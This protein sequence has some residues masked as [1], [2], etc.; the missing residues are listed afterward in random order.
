MKKI[1]AVIAVIAVFAVNGFSA[2]AV[3][4][5][6]VEKK[7]PVKEVVK[8]LKIAPP[9]AVKPSVV[10]VSEVVVEDFEAEKIAIKASSYMGDASGM[11]ETAEDKILLEQDTKRFM[12]GKKSAKLTY[13]QI[14]A[15]EKKFA[16]ITL[17]SEN[18]MDTNNAISFYVLAEKGKGSIAVN[19]FDT[20]W[21][22]WV[23]QTINADKKEWTL[24]TIKDSEFVSDARE[25]KWGNI[26]RV[27]LIIKGSGVFY[28]DNVKFIKAVK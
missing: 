14:P 19:L 8:D 26:N 11:E 24:I 3:K 22:K 9:E 25:G 13:T 7:A 6:V 15:N 20:K 1:A 4:K 28:F 2:D 17:A 18:A 21:K 10:K 16:Q 12:S 27:Q 23:S 5:P